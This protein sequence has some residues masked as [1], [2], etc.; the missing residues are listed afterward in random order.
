MKV[1][2]T[3]ASGHVGINLCRQLTM[4]G[5]EVRVLVH[6]NFGRLPELNVEIIRGDLFDHQSLLQLFGGVEVVFHLAAKITIDQKETNAV[7]K[8]NVEGT[9]NVIKACKEA[10]VKKLVHF[11]TIH[12]LKSFGTEEK[13]DESN[14]LI[15]GSK[16]VYEQSKAEAEKLVIVASAEGLDAVILNPTAIVGPYDYKPSYLGQAL[17]KIYKNQLPMLVPGGYNFVDVRDVADASIKAATFGRSGER[18]VL[19]GHWLSL[20]DLSIQIG[21][22]FNRKTPTF[23]APTWVARVGIPFIQSWAK[24]S[25]SHPLYTAESLEILKSAS[26]NIS[27]LK[28]TKELGYA[29]R[30]MDE[31][32]KDTFTWYKENQV[33]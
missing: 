33:V 8:I 9:A 15:S 13:L 7:F 30:P 29:P 6:N 20:K 25:G 2:A 3:G 17:I 18:Y 11:S 22:L 14:P 28:A 23:K 31:T 16:I 26:K 27:Y 1:A 21:E 24:L 32:L 10:R 19:G 12:T 5:H 4:Q